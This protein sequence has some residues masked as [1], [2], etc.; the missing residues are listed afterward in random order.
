MLNDK[1]DSSQQDRRVYV[2]NLSYDVKWHHLKDYMRGGDYDI[3]VSD[4]MKAHTIQL[5]MSS[6]QM[7]YYFQ[8]ECRRWACY[9]AE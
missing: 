5:A 9:P 6:L 3:L 8:M 7:Y 2:G 4:Y 1:R